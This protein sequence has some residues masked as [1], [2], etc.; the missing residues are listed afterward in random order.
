MFM[1]Y[2]AGIYA[3]SYLRY[4]FKETINEETLRLCLN[5]L[6]CIPLNIFDT[7]LRLLDSQSL[8]LWFGVIEV[9]MCGP[10]ETELAHINHLSH[11]LILT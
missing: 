9:F 4:S 7:S 5:F 10:Q 8:A 2:E 6:P 11:F 3:N 1:H